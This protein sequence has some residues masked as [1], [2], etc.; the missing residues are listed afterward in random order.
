VVGALR[1]DR[2][3]WQLRTRS[4]GLVAAL[5]G[6]TASSSAFNI[7]TPG[8]DSPAAITTTAARGA[9]SRALHRRGGEQAAAVWRQVEFRA[10]PAHAPSSPGAIS[11][12]WLLSRLGRTISEW[13]AGPLRRAQ[14]VSAAGASRTLALSLLSAFDGDFGKALREV[15]DPSA[16]AVRRVPERRRAHHGPARRQALAGSP[17]HAAVT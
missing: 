13:R 12:P 15:D 14:T 11:G 9:G 3:P 6:S 5:T 17:R 10:R 7:A 4:P 8:A 16:G 1:Q 2:R